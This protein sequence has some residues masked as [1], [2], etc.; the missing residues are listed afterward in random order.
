[1]DIIVSKAACE[2]GLLAHFVMSLWTILFCLAVGAVA[3]Y[4]V[5]RM[6]RKTRLLR[7]VPES[8]DNPV[9]E[10]REISE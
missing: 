5:Y 10:S 6:G 2:G 9:I 4:I 8:G 7:T 3:C 1:M